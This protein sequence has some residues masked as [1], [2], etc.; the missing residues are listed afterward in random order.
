[1]TKILFRAMLALVV[2]VAPLGCDASPD[3]DPVLT[4]LNGAWSARVMGQGLDGLTFSRA[5]TY[6][7]YAYARAPEGASFDSWGSFA[8]Q[9]MDGDAFRLVFTPKG[10]QRV[11]P[12]VGAFTPSGYLSLRADTA[13]APAQLFFK[14]TY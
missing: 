9:H 11:G 2:A 3:I 12:F 7:A 4:S 6:T 13:G 5:E 1:M 8:V 10:G 14:S